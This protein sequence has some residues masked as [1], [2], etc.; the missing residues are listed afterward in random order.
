[1]TSK[2]QDIWLHLASEF[3]FQVL[4]LLSE[5]EKGVLSGKKLIYRKPFSNNPEINEDIIKYFEAKGVPLVKS[6]T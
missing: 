4:D 3:N 1:M 6:Y 5:A 2:D